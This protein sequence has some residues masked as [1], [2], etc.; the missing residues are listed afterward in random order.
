MEASSVSFDGFIPECSS[1]QDPVVIPGFC[2]VDENSS[3]ESSHSLKQNV[4]EEH[5]PE[6]ICEEIDPTIEAVQNVATRRWVKLKANKKK[7]GLWDRLAS[8]IFEAEQRLGPAVI[9]PSDF[10]EIKQQNDLSMENLRLIM[11]KW[12]LPKTARPM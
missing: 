1:R 2:L 6:T 12:R 9:R 8:M 10:K 11:R 4:G 3:K 7:A 5:T